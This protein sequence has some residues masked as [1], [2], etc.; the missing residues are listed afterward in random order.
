MQ[1]GVTFTVRMDFKRWLPLG[2]FLVLAL[3][4]AAIGGFATASSV[5][6]WFPSLRKPDWCPPS[7][8]FG[9][10][11]TLLYLIMAVSTWRVWRLGDPFSARRTVSLYGAQLTL[12]VLWS[13]L[14]FGL[15]QP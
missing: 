3:A 8:F 1:V 11:W 6:T 13:I 15:R 9:P 4:A 5:Q 7:G 14:F 2:L 10:I 12:N